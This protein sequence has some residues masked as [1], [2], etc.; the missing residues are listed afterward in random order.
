MKELKILIVDDDPVVRFL[1]EQTILKNGIDS[2]VLTF[3][4]G[5]EA[6]DYLEN[7]RAHM[8]PY[9]ILLDIHMPI[10]N[11]W[12]L[13]TA[14]KAKD[15]S[16]PIEVAVVSSSHT[17]ADRE[18]AHRYEMVSIFLS[19]PLKNV[20]EIRKIINLQEKKYSG[21]KK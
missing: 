10:M 7:V 4:N 14:L 1:H 12:E 5:E 15:F 2:E 21:M 9:L 11:G 16:F 8:M 3:T 20:D 6:L 13:L 18:R 17:A 19:K